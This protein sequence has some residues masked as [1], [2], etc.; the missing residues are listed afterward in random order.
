M[1]INDL[2][3]G[4]RGKRKASTKANPFTKAKKPYGNFIDVDADAAPVLGRGFA[5]DPMR[6]RPSAVVVCERLLQRLQ[7]FKASSKIVRL[8]TGR[9]SGIGIRYFEISDIS[10]TQILSPF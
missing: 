4:R 2:A 3:S 10:D 8:K 5:L 7:N 6:L 1:K 9:G